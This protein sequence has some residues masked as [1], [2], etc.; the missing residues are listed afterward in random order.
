LLGTW[1]APWPPNGGNPSVLLRRGAE[2]LL[3]EFRAACPGVNLAETDVVRSYW[4]LLPLK[5]GREPGRPGALAD[6]DRVADY[7]AQGGPE[8]MLLA[9]GVKFTTARDTAE[10]AVDAVLAGLKLGSRP[11]R[12]RT[13]RLDDGPSSRPEGMAD[14][15]QHAIREEMAVRLSDV[16]VRRT[17]MSVPP[18]PTPEAVAAAAR[19]AAGDLGW[20]PARE[21]AEIDDVRQELAPFGRARGP[22]A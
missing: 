8:G 20:S 15:I 17:S 13:V 9:E 18:G 5:Q 22:D 1:Y 10:R 4:G 12:T 6:R 3:A 21:R 16:M 11:C 19:I 14:Q 7:G 2:V